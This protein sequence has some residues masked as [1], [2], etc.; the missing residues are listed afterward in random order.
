MRIISPDISSHDF[1][2]SLKHALINRI[3][4]GLLLVV[5]V[6]VPFSVAQYMS[7]GWSTAYLFHGLLG[8]LSVTMVLGKR[9]LT[10]DF[11]ATILG[12]SCL[13]VGV[14]GLSE[15]GLLATEWSYTVL[16]IIVVGVVLSGRAAM[17]MFLIAMCA[18]GAFMWAYTT[19]GLTFGVD[20]VAYHRQYYPWFLT[21]FASMVLPVFVLQQFR[22]NQRALY[23]LLGE[24]ERQRDVIA[25]QVYY[26]ELTNLPSRRLVLDRLDMAIKRLERLERLEQMSAVLFIDLDGFKR[27]NDVYGHAAGDEVLRVSGARMK[28]AVRGDDTVARYGGDEFLVILNIIGSHAHAAQVAR[29]IINAIEQPVVFEGSSIQISASIGI[30]MFSGD[31]EVTRETLIIFADEAMYEAKNNGKG[32]YAFYH[33]DHAEVYHVQSA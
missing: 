10:L 33:G 11:K 26:D 5:G 16:G 15:F 20:A 3:W 30:K 24:V 23:D 29:R 6:S 13:V 22:F 12:L 19:G 14:F 21:I 32:C 1:V 2:E 28:E 27:A 31:D 8:V 17:V 25:E 9:A 7:A 18:M 4:M